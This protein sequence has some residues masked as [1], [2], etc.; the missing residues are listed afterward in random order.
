VVLGAAEAEHAL[1]EGGAAGVE[2]LGDLGGADEGQGLD[3]GV[4]DEG[5]DDLAGCR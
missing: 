2:D 4:I 5:L 1:A 3:V